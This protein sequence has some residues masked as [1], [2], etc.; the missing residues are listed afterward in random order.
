MKMKIVQ[1]IAVM[2][3]PDWIILM[4]IERFHLIQW[5]SF[6]AT[7]LVRPFLREDFEMPMLENAL[8]LIITLICDTVTTGILYNFIQLYYFD[9]N[10]GILCCYWYFILLYI[11][12]YYFYTAGIFY[13]YTNFLL[14]YFVLL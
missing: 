6:S 10:A 13:Y 3:D 12:L 9:T 8:R 7:Q 1:I 14:R 5:M 11:Y 4:I 2:T